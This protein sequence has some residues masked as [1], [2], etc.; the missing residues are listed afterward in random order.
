MSLSKRDSNTFCYYYSMR[1]YYQIT[2]ISGL[3]VLTA[4]GSNDTSES[5]LPINTTEET[6]KEE[7]N[8]DQ[9]TTKK[10]DTSK[11]TI[12]KKTDAIEDK[13]MAMVLNIPEVV[14]MNKKIEKNS[15]GK[16]TLSSF[17]SSNPGD[18]QEYYS[19]SVSED[20]GD[21]MATYFQFHVYPDMTIKYYDVIE[22]QELT[23][24]EWKNKK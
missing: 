3:L 7:E 13:I 18:D 12:Q 2:V 8:L 19:V 17:I 11:E 9:E 21:A 20:N 4:C 14:E 16:R 23:L 1:K 15:K 6:V 5:D 24:Q 10:Y 22:D